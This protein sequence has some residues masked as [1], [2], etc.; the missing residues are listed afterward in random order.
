MVVTDDE[1]D[2][3]LF[4]VGN[5]LN[6]LDAAVKYDNQPHAGGM[7]VVHTLVADS[8]SLLVAVRDIEINVCGELLQKAIDQCHRRATIHIVVSI[9]KNA[10]LA[11]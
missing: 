11:S 2:A 3:Q 6:G 5:L 8:I 1:V 7:G 4:G 9:N 10:F